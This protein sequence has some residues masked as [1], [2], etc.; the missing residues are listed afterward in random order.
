MM[1]GAELKMER[2]HVMPDK[3]A[4]FVSM[5]GNVVQGEVLNGDKGMM[6]G[7]GGNTKLAGAELADLKSRS[8]P[9]SEMEYTKPGYAMELKGIEMMEGK[10]AY[11][12][13][14]TTP[15]GKK[16]TNFYDVESS[17]RIHTVVT[18][19]SGAQLMVTNVAISNYKD[20]DGILIPYTITMTNSAMPA[21]MKMETKTIKINSDFDQSVFTVE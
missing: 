2:Y 19:G 20:V 14:V 4:M 6:S 11:K 9:F 5:G 7:M 15:S 8:A 10:K 13:V 18:E 12:V 21:P 3:Y 16:E 17:L 1:R